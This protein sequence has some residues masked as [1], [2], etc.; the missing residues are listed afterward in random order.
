MRL[1]APDRRHQLV[2]VARDVFAA[3]GFHATSMDDVA[4]AAGVTKP[5]LYQH[6]TS[7][8]ALYIELLET[9]GEELLAAIAAAAG[10]V[11][12]GRR[13]VEAG[14]GAYF[15][16]VMSNR[17]SF[18]LLF[19][20]SVRNDEDFARVVERV[21]EQI[22]EAISGFIEI[23]ATSEHRRVLAHALVGV[24]EATARRALNDPDAEHSPE[25]LATWLSEMAW[26]GLRGV[27]SDDLPSG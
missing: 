21:I 1:A 4:V 15:G 2:G 16:Y 5:V 27:R 24:S 14:F 17:M 19:G 10:G 25:R 8:R 18:R 22:A 11:S 7:K 9:V 20:A 3:K 6:F 12:G 23:D 26:F 13:R